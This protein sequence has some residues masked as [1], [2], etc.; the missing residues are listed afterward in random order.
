MAKMSCSSVSTVVKKRNLT[1]REM[2]NI[3]FPVEVGI[4]FFAPLA[5]RFVSLSQGTNYLQIPGRLLSFLSTVCYMYV[6][7]DLISYTKQSFNFFFDFFFFAKQPRQVE[8]QSQEEGR[9]A[10]VLQ[11]HAVQRCKPNGFSF[12]KNFIGKQMRQRIVRR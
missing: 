7:L 11:K 4:F 9:T 10:V 6:V 8:R 1:A 3:L 5:K 2:Q 12:K